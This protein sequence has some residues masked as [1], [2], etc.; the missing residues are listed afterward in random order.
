[1]KEDHALQVAWFVRSAASHSSLLVD[2]EQVVFAVEFH[3][4][5]HWKGLT[6]EVQ[7]FAK[8]SNQ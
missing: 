4:V 3:H 7:P 2:A 5:G 1:M 6:D 8:G